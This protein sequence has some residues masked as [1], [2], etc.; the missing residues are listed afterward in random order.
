MVGLQK[1]EKKINEIEL[2]IVA[3]LSLLPSGSIYEYIKL[4]TV[5][6]VF[7]EKGIRE[8]IK[9]NEVK[10]FVVL[11]P[12][13]FTMCSWMLSLFHFIEDTSFLIHETKRNLFICIVMVICLNL[14]VDFKSIYHLCIFFL[15]VNTLV[16]IL[17]FLKVEPVFD[18][19]EKY[20][21][22]S[23]D[24]SVHLDL[25]KN[26]NFL[27]FRAGS[28]YLNPNVYMII[29]LVCMCVFFQQSFIQKNVFNTGMIIVSLLS[30]FLAGSRTAFIIM[31]LLFLLYFIN[32]N[33]KKESKL[34]YIC[35]AIIIFLSFL[36][37]GNKY[38]FFDIASGV[39]NSLN[40]KLQ[41][42]FDY[43][44]N[45]NFIS[46]MFGSLGIVNITQVD[47]EIAY[48]FAYYGVV[49]LL[50]FYC[51]VVNIKFKQKKLKFLTVSIR[52]VQVFLSC[53]AT[54]LLCM[55]ICTFFLAIAFSQP[56]EMSKIN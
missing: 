43:F 12:I 41:I 15:C 18:F 13:F 16:Q 26:K 35:I 33:I 29:P 39:N 22:S 31:F 51:V 50:W 37:I 52:L 42:F 30:I 55:P 8:D 49:G 27:T 10:F 3:F 19:I 4:A 11:L 2:Y 28:I 23:E 47:F 38:R 46:F 53:T 44:K 21:V 25:A 1:K 6:I 32:L 7:I 14:K 36:P 40:V 24:G 34:L 45:I 17:E 9:L 54:I 20:Y 48:I 5:L 56:V